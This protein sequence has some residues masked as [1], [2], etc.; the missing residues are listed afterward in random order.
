MSTIAVT[1][2]SGALGSVVC[3]RLERDGARVFR[4][5]RKIADLTDEAQVERAYDQAGPL[6]GSVHCAGGWAAGSS[7]EAFE[8]MIALNLRSALLCCNAA[9]RRMDAS[10]RVVNVAAWTAVGVT[11]LA[12]STAY[13]ASKAGVIA[14]TRAFAEKGPARCNC[15]APAAMTTPGNPPS[16]SLV[17]VEEVAD[18]IAFL[19]SASAPNGAVLTFP[20]RG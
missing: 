7:V 19:L 4:I 8:K 18:A 11:G 14:L 6:S 5:D 9:F 3:A 1:G 15:V 12:G 2:A 10:G 17:P 20:P 16:P 13:N